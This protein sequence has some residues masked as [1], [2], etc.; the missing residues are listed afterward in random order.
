M[1]RGRCG[2]PAWSGAVG[3][4]KESPHHPPLTDRAHSSCPKPSE[5]QLHARGLGPAVGC[6]YHLRQNLG[7]LALPSPFVLDAYS[8]RLVGC[9]MANDLRTGLVLDALN[10]A[11]YDRRPQP[12]AIH[13]S[14]RGGQYTAVE[15]GSRLREAGLLPS[16]GSVADAYDDS[17]AESFVSTLKRE[18]IHRRYSWP[19]RQRARK[20]GHLRVRRGLLRHQEEAPRPGASQP[21]RVEEARPRGGAVA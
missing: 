14:D 2:K 15:F 10:M 5:A 13:R 20:D 1:W 21:L 18:L 7:G 8:R 12:G 16:M 17:M 3:P 4:H 19:N 9:S 11:I 6:G